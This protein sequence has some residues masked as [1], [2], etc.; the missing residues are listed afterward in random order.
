MVDA[1]ECHDAIVSVLGNLDARMLLRLGRVCKAFN[2]LIRTDGVLRTGVLNSFQGISDIP[3]VMDYEVYANILR[4]HY[5]SLR[6]S[7]V[8]WRKKVTVAVQHARF[9]LASFADYGDRLLSPNEF[10]TI[11]ATFYERTMCAFET[12][13]GR[14]V[15]MEYMRDWKAEIHS[16]H[17][18][19]HGKP[20]F[21]NTE[22]IIDRIS[23]IASSSFC[24]HSSEGEKW[25]FPH[26]QIRTN[27]L[28]LLEVW[29]HQN[30]AAAFYDDDGGGN[31][32]YVGDLLSHSEEEEEEEDEEEEDSDD[33][34][35]EEDVV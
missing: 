33:S 18:P 29:R 34:D 14:M 28:L 17:H 5:R 1:L 15:V 24:F 26:G 32:D 13:E 8:C 3:V 6:C 19:L 2:S 7:A 31:V 21:Y 35:E 16:W 22:G 10:D 23:G 30:A 11:I 4:W 20:H 27:G 25:R 12:T 9:L